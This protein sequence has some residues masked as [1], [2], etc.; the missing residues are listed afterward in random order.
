MRAFRKNRAFRVTCPNCHAA[1]RCLPEQTIRAVT[2]SHC[3]T[4]FQ[5]PRHVDADRPISEPA[6]PPPGDGEGKP[7][8]ANPRV[9]SATERFLSGVVIA[10]VIGAGVGARSE[11]EATSTTGLDGYETVDR[12]YETA[13]HS[14]RPT[15]LS[16]LGVEDASRMS[17]MIWGVLTPLTAVA[18]YAI[19]VALARVYRLIQRAP[20]SAP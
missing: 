3:K 9:V 6:S 7:V 20:D 8:E 13:Y 15:L 10:Y 12:G 5:V 2:C 17:I 4:P 19:G 16:W 14:F 1:L 18:L 11:W